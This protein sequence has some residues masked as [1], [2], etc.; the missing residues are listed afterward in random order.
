MLYLIGLGL[1]EKGISIEGKEAIKKC[2]RVYLE[3]YTVKFPYPIKKLG[4]TLRKKI[5]EFGRKEVESEMLIKEAKKQN[6]ALLVYGCP[7]FATTHMSLILDAEEAKTK[8]KIIYSTSVFDTL[9]ETGLQLYKFG[10][11]TSMPRWEAH[12]NPESFMEYVEQNHSIKAHSLILI[13][14]GLDFSDALDELNISCKN[15]NFD[16]DNLIV[17]SRMGTERAKIF[18]GAPEKLKKIKKIEAP[19][20]FIIPGEMHF[21]EKEAVERFEV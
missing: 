3:N 14:I 19:F 12:F 21:L 13:D 15:R 20:C 16:F 2:K 5:I 11:I 17:C 8:T 7:L 9:A 10:K 1:N 4:K 18:Y 6:I